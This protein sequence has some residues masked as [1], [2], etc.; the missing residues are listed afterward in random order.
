MS[1]IVDL[2]HFGLDSFD[3]RLALLAA[4][5]EDDALN[6]VVVAVLAGD[7]ETRLVANGDGS[8]IAQQH[9]RAVVRSQHGVADVFDRMHETDTAHHRRLLPEV[10]GLSADVDRSILPPLAATSFTRRSTSSTAVHRFLEPISFSRFQPTTGS[11][12]TFAALVRPAITLAALA[13]VDIPML[14][15]LG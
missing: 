9:R 5:H 2:R 14:H 10:Y 8:D 1:E 13:I 12:S 15:S 4:P 3:R 7:A 11:T 6:D